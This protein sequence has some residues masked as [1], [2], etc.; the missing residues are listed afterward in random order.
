MAGIRFS[1]GENTRIAIV[2]VLGCIVGLTFGDVWMGLAIGYFLY[3]LWLLQQAHLVDRWLETGA[4]RRNVPDTDGV[5]GHI[6]Q[7]IFRRKTNERKRKARLKKIVGVYNQSAAA[8]PDATV[9]T[10]NRFEIVW[11]N[12]AAN[13]YLGIRG[14]RD[15]GQRIDNLVRNPE[16]Q[17]YVVNFDPNKEIEF[18][19]PGNQQLI[20]AVRCVNYAENLCLFIAR[21][22]SQRVMLRDTL[23]TFVA[24]ASHELKTPLTVVNGYLEML[25][26]D[27]SL[28]PDVVRKLRTADKHA[29]RMSDIVSDLLT[30]S[31]LENQQPDEKK[32][33]QLPLAALLQSTVTDLAGTLAAHT[34]HIELDLDASL[35][36]TGSEFEIKS[37]L[38]NLCQNAIQHTPPSTTIKVQ[39]TAQDHG[40]QLVIEDNGPGIDAQHLNHLTERFY[41][42][43]NENSRDTGGTGLGL[44]I[45]KHIVNRHQG[46]LEVQSSPGAGTT[47]IVHFPAE[48]I[49]QARSLASA[50]SNG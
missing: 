28:S 42:V 14:K 39:W 10:N 22:V 17:E 46:R 29:Q 18:R 19:A 34:H 15:A 48:V 31:R 40:A 6:E 4:K 49:S 47:F 21:D 30:L 43:D 12:N 41:R 11:A 45:V 36:L 13:R 38:T 27:P 33:V 25:L 5:L 32:L 20:L 3:C 8:L 7:L 37:L 26:D 35:C 44:A 2:A 23:S 1:Y 16:F 50:T 24:N 9:V